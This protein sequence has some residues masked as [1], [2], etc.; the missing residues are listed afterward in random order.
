M[1]PRSVSMRYRNSHSLNLPLFSPEIG[2]IFGQSNKYG[3][4]APGLD[5]AFGFTGEEYVQKALDRGW[6]ICDE[7]QTSPAIYNEMKEFSFELNLEPIRG[8]NPHRLVHPHRPG[9]RNGPQRLQGR[10]R[11]PE[12][13]L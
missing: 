2:D 11:I 10:Q 6:L 1:M 7:T 13:R 12:R 5:F 9:H 4:M 3:P 8:L